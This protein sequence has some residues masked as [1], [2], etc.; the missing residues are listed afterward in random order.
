MI[1]TICSTLF[2]L[3]S[4]IA[5]GQLPEIKQHSNYVTIETITHIKYTCAKQ[6]EIYVCY[7]YQ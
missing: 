5:P 1:Q 4:T 3:Q 7:T 6:R 2:C